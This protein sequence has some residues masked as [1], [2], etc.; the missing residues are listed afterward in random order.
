M[1]DQ[2]TCSEQCPKAD[3]AVQIAVK[4]P[5]ILDVWV[6]TAFLA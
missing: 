1:C 6:E 2:R 5:E 3:R 4:T